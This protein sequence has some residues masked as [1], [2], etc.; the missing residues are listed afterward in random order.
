MFATP[1]GLQRSPF[2]ASGAEQLFYAGLPQQEALARMRFLVHNQRRLGLL[3]GP[4]GCGKSLLLDLFAEECGSHPW[5]VVRL[6]L[7]GLAVREFLWQVNLQLHTS[8]RSGEDTL[9][10]WQRLEA[11][12]RQNLLQGESLILLVDDA[13]QAGPDV[14]AQLVRLVQ[15]APQT[16]GTLSVVL[17]TTPQRSGQL[18]SRLLDLVDLRIDLEPWDEEDTVGYLQLASVQAGA[19]RP[20]FSEAALVEIHRCTEGVAR[21]VNRLA[22]YALLVGLEA[23]LE[24]VDQQTVTQAHAALTRPLQMAHR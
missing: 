20:L 13:D 12:F 19:E 1:W 15:L 22:D 23:G 6:S 18:G 14:L 17:A 11:R 5:A 21:Q 16:V 3:E 7:W 24:Q 8:P 2:Q 9:R 10:L 4:A